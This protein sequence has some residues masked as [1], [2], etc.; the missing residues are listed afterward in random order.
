[1][2]LSRALCK[3]ILYAVASKSFSTGIILFYGL[4]DEFEAKGEA[5]LLFD[6]LEK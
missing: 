3:S 4:G 5:S 1:M 2:V 6:Y